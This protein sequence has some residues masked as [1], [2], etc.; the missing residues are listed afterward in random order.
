[1]ESAAGWQRLKAPQTPEFRL[2]LH[3]AAR[4]EMDSVLA[5][6]RFPKLVSVRVRLRKLQPSGSAKG[7]IREV[8]QTQTAAWRAV[9]ALGS[10]AAEIARAA[11]VW[12]P[13]GAA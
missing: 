7:P 6:Q 9:V 5:R 8:E 13:G 3:L 10:R 2:V 11:L 4:P 12:V 1:M